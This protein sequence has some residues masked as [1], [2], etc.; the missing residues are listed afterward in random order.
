M[1]DK[2]ESERVASPE[3]V[4]IHLKSGLYNTGAGWR[5]GVSFSPRVMILTA[6]TSDE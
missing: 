6:L 1:E 4:P 3:L 2:N 5:L